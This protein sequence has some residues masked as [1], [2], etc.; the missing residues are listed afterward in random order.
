MKFLNK[1]IVMAGIS[2]ITAT[3]AAVPANAQ[4]GGVATANTILAIAQVKALGAAYKQI[5]TTYGTYFTQ[6]QSKRQEIQTLLQQLDKNGDKQ[7]DQAEMDAAEAAKSPVLAQVEA[8]Q[9]ELSTLQQPIVK[10]QMYVIDQIIDKYD[11]AQQA[12]VASRKISYILAP[13]AFVWAPE[14]INVT[15]LISAEIDKTLPTANSN[16]PADWKPDQQTFQAYQQVQQ[17]LGAAAQAQA[18][19]AQQ[20]PA[21]AAPASSGKK[22]PSGR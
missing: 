6:M 4:V 5:E 17:L 1:A 18:A 3:T 12:V 9:K 16:P 2:A 14:A 21:A 19:R 7:V 8:K 13:E 20:Q 15:S 10:A 11:A 22:Q